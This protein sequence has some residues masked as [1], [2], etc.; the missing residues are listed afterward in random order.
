MQGSLG[1]RISRALDDRALSP[2]RCFPKVF[3]ELRAFWNVSDAE[4]FDA[5]RDPSLLDASK[6]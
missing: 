3:A 6:T 5:W 2:E 1:Q 4:A